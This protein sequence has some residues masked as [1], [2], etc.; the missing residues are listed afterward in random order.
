M[1]EHQAAGRLRVTQ[2][3]STISHIGRN[4]ATVRALG[5]HGI[6]SSVEVPDNEATRGMV[7]QVRFL[8]TVEE[9]PG[10]TAGGKA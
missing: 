6:G 10:T 9:L 1:A 7:R 3:K 4:R 8:V 2:V 5:L